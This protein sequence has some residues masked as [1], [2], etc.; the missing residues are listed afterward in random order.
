V[1]AAQAR[2]NSGGAVHFTFLF[3]ASGPALGNAGLFA[4]IEIGLDQG[5]GAPY[6]TFPLLNTT[7]L[8]TPLWS[9][10]PPLL[11]LSWPFLSHCLICKTIVAH[12]DDKVSLSLKG[13]DK[14][15]A[16]FPTEL[17]FHP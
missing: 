9:R 14:Y 4:R 6:S 5:L 8:I 3:G 7:D 12:F 10:A 16:V 1:G 17:A 2:I 11:F 13:E 15:L